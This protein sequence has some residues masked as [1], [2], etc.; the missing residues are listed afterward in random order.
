MNALKLMAAALCCMAAATVL[1]QEPAWNATAIKECDR[2]C[3]V[4]VLDGYLDA[5]LKKDPKAVPPLS[6]DVRMTENTGQMDVGEGVLWR[7]K[8]EPTSFKIT[9]ADPVSGEVAFQGRLKVQGRDTLAAIRLKVDR[10][11]IAEIEQ[12]HAGGIAPQAVEKIGAFANDCVRHEN[13]YRTVNNPAPGGRMMPGPQLPDPT[14]SRASR[15][16]RS[17]CSRARSR[18]TRRSLPT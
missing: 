1:A 5:L 16:S 15:S 18:S 6:I 7:S 10:G 17:A 3:L 14:R 9:V 2:A 4:G 12:L 11:R 8:T 13:G